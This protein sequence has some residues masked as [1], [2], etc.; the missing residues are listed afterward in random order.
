M[1]RMEFTMINKILL[2]ISLSVLVLP[3]ATPELL[4]QEASSQGLGDFPS[5][6]VY[7][8]GQGVSSDGLVVVGNGYPGMD[9][10]EAYRKTEAGGM[11]GLGELPGGSFFSDALAESVEG[12]VNVGSKDLLGPIKAAS[13]KGLK[14][15]MTLA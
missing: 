7:S 15:I 11:V 3:L 13:A 5:D 9:D 14:E 4:A 6:E 8:T 1:N 10:D 12:S 2:L